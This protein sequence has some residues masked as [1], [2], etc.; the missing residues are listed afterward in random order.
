MK[1]SLKKLDVFFGGG[2][3]RTFFGWHTETLL[4]LPAALY[5]LVNAVLYQMTISTLK[6]DPAL[7]RDD[8]VQ[9]YLV[10]CRPRS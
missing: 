8:A 7:S 9:Q 2:C 3:H 1:R 10:L 6:W 5:A 4:D